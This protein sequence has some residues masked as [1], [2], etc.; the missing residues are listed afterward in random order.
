MDESA[1]R[2]SRYFG[3]T[4]ELMQVLARACGHRRLSDF[5]T[6]DLTTW[7]RE[8]ADLSEIR[9]ARESR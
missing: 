4:I 3:A 5:C 6:A 8:I 9:Y 1:K 7:K 2:L